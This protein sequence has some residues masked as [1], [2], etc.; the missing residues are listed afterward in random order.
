[1]LIIS[2]FLFLGSGCSGCKKQFFHNDQVSCSEEARYKSQSMEMHGEIIMYFSVK[3]VMERRLFLGTKPISPGIRE[4]S[5]ISL[6]GKEFA[7]ILVN[8][9]KDGKLWLI[10]L[11]D[12]RPP[13]VIFKKELN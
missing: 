4:S 11:N 2:C 10:F 1:M 3:S 6:T 5:E 13:E 7:H 9:N 8:K 12:K